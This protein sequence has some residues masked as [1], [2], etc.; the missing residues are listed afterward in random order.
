MPDSTRNSVGSLKTAHNTEVIVANGPLILRVKQLP[1]R[2]QDLSLLLERDIASDIWG[3]RS[4]IH[5]LLN[6]IK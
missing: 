2:L 4:I 5:L 3:L 1:R 6:F